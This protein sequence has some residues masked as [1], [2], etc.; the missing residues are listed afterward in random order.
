MKPV[1]DPRRAALALALA[2]AIA[3]LTPP[4][5]ATTVARLT[6]PAL[7]RAATAIV[8]GSC[9]SAESFVR[10]DGLIATRYRF[11]VREFLKGGGETQRYAFVQLG[12]TVGDRTLFIPGAPRFTPGEEVVIF[13]AG[14]EEPGKPAVTVGLGQGKF[15]VYWDVSTRA[16]RVRRSIGALSVV[17]PPRTGGADPAPPADPADQAAPAGQPVLETFLAEIRTLVAE[18]KKEKDRGTS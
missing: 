6:R 12:G 13:V 7:V 4:A 8:W 14:G 5:P 3:C 18:E 15:Q 11:T 16:M 1:E 17:P 9:E 10:P 2:A